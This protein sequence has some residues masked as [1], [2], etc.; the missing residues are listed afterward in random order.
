MADRSAATPSHA[1]QMLWPERSVYAQ[2]VDD[3]ESLLEEAMRRKFGR[4]TLRL[5]QELRALT[6]LSPARRLQRQRERLE[7][8]LRRLD[9]GWN[10]RLAEARRRAE[11]QEERLCRHGGGAPP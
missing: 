4:L 2:R 9:S 8:M 11:R 5:T 3:A 6:L 7:D 1:A 10:L